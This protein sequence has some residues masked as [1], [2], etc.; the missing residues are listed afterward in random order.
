M[1]IHVP[2]MPIGAFCFGLVA[3]YITYRTLVR[4]T[5]AA[6]IGDLS[7]VLS[8]LGGAVVV[9]LFDPAGGELFGWYAIGLPLGMLVYIVTLGMLNKGDEGTARRELAK[10]LGATAAGDTA[11]ADGQVAEHNGR[12]KAHRGPNAVPGGG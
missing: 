5:K 1:S 12:A 9:N 4:T 6:A 11:E 10:V 7:A 8:A 2:V 3:G